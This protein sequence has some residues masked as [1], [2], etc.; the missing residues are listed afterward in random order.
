MFFCNS[1]A[2][3]NEAAIKLARLNGKPKSRY[4]IV[5]LTGSF[6]GRIQGQDIGLVGN[7]ANQNV[8]G[9]RV[10][11]LSVDTFQTRLK[12][13]MEAAKTRAEPISPGLAT[14]TDSTD[15]MRQVRETLQNILYHDD[16][17]VSLEHQVAEINKNQVM[18]NVAITILSQQFRLLQAAVTERV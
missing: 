12:E 4:K 1:G 11:D 17:N 2:E 5:T 9:Y 8:P 18:H 10:R 14:S 3:A 6:H 15:G 7:L 16:T 13:A